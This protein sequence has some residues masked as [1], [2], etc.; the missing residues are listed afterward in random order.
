MADDE[1]HHQYPPSISEKCAEGTV[2]TFQESPIE[3]LLI[4]VLIIMDGIVAWLRLEVSSLMC[5]SAV[6]MTIITVFT[7]GFSVP[8]VPLQD[9]MNLRDVSALQS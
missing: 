6:A 8:C 9:D 7:C 5:R 4:V 3:D 2:R 1:D